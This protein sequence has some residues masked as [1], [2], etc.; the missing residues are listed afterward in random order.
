MVSW[1]MD[2]VLALLVFISFGCSNVCHWMLGRALL[3]LAAPA[4]FRT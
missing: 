1:T 4:V 2:C 3:M